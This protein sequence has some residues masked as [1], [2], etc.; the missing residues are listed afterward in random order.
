[1]RL[2]TVDFGGN[3]EKE[4]K[5][6]RFPAAMLLIS[7]LIWLSLSSA[8]K[9][10]TA[11]LDGAYNDRNI[12]IPSYPGN[13]IRETDTVYIANDVKLTTDIVIKGMLMVRSTGSL[14]GSKNLVV[15]Q[16]GKLL[17][18]GITISEGLA[19][20]GLVYNKHIMEV[21]RDFI[22]SGEVINQESMV[23]GNIVDNIGLITGQGG[24]FM[25]NRKFINSQTGILKGCIDVCSNNFINVD[26]G[27]ID[28]THLSFCGHRIFSNVYLSADIRKDNIV[29][30][31]RNATSADYK[32]YQV[33]RS[34]DGI[35]YVPLAT[36]N[37][38]QLD[39]LS[40]PFRYVDEE[41]I[42]S[43]SLFYRLKVT[44]NDNTE[45]FIPPVE[46]GNIPSTGTDN[47]F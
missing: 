40:L 28:S 43:N 1:M 30:S 12:W 19:S 2:N 15:L 32:K 26:G 39:D 42:K 38:S 13:I 18:F 41:V 21:A 22:N 44:G 33:E 35:H 11:N 4:N 46:V 27:T 36:V 10:Y 5:C 9:I 17:N 6:N 37:K 29:L 16:S 7:S 20:K 23:V 31:L 14:M 25:A 34:V 3:D 47:R 45:T 24:S 8:A